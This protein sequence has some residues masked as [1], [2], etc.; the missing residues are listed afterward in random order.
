[1]SFQP[2][3]DESEEAKKAAAKA[4]T[5]G[6]NKASKK[7]YGGDERNDDQDFLE[8]LKEPN[9]VYTEE[10]LD[11]LRKKAEL[12]K[13]E[14]I[15]MM[16]QEMFNVSGKEKSLD[17]INLNTKE[18]ILDY[19][20][21]LYNRLSIL[22]KT[23]YYLE[24]LDQLLTGLTKDMNIEN[25]KKVTTKLSS[26]MSEKQSEER[27]KKNKLKVKKTTKPLMTN[28]TKSEYDTFLG[29]AATPAQKPDD[30]YDMDNDFM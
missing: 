19:S 26:I 9:R 23:D 13:E 25:V 15:L 18:D 7:K 20:F 4:S 10:E 16:N 24:F 28:D 11:D 17:D 1:M 12:K 14:S 6:K 30:A 29:D 21:R 3:V 22:S 5:T 27:E 2:K 8:S